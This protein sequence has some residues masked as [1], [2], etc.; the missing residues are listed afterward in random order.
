M[1]HEGWLF[2]L[3][4]G[5]SQS[6]MANGVSHPL[7]GSFA[8]DTFCGFWLVVSGMSG[9]ELLVFL[10]SLVLSESCSFW[11]LFFWFQ[12]VVPTSSTNFLFLLLD[13]LW[14]SVDGCYFFSS[15]R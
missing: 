6:C 13:F 10:T 7:S 14:L 15:S 11:F 3:C 9:S 12:F 5:T 1:N 8:F 4:K 2:F